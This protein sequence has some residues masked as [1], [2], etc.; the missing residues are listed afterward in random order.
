M[1]QIDKKLRIGTVPFA[2]SLPLDGYLLEAM[3]QAQVI[4]AVPSELGRML[5][6]GELD[7][8]M[9]S[10]IELLR[11][12]EYGMVP[13]FGV[14]SDGPVRSVCLYTRVAPEQLESVALDGNS[15]TSVVLLKIL[16][17]EFWGV[18]PRFVYY[19]PPMQNGL[20]LAQ[21][22]LAIGDSTFVTPPEDVRTI[23]L[24]EAW[25]LHTGLPFV[26]A[27]WITRPGLD[28]SDLIEP[29]AQALRLGLERIKE[30]AEHCA[31]RTGYPAAFFE[32]YFTFCIQYQ[33]TPRHEEGMALFFRKAE[34]FITSQ[35]ANA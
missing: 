20:D 5:A 16:L 21:A 11:Q 24:G 31:E 34:A 10:T 8:A 32:E 12:P 29:F 33:L 23:D 14:C 18:S 9:L 28:P 15:L 17:D 25:K 35:T 13:G 30:L 27:G 1:Q 6:Q 4:R 19:A 7:A 26:F 22:A 3:P 2:N